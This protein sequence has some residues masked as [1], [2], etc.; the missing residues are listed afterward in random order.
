MA[1]QS[2]TIR[3]GMPPLQENA[4]REVMTASVLGDTGFFGSLRQN[5]NSGTRRRTAI[6]CPI[7]KS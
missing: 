3:R 2:R 4:G 1:A 6:S 7:C 5:I